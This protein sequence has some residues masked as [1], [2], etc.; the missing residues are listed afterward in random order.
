M[1]EFVVVSK[2]CLRSIVEI[3]ARQIRLRSTQVVG[4]QTRQIERTAVVAYEVGS[5]KSSSWAVSRF[6]LIISFLAD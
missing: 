3:I 1:V 2:N 4:G 5:K 6:T